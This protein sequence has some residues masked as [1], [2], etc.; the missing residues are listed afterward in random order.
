MLRI[1]DVMV[2]CTTRYAFKL[3]VKLLPLRQLQHA[4][5]DFV[6]ATGGD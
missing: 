2:S 1:T 3:E 5:L 6:L 4:V